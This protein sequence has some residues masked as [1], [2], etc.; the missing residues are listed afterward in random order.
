MSDPR[1]AG[2]DSQFACRKL[3]MRR[4]DIMKL[5]KEIIGLAYALFAVVALGAYDPKKDAAMSAVAQKY[6]ARDNE[7]V[8]ILES[9]LIAKTSGFM[10]KMKNAGLGDGEA[11]L[12]SR[13]EF[14]YDNVKDDFCMTD[15][16]MQH[17]VVMADVA[18]EQGVKGCE[19]YIRALDELLPARAR[20]ECLMKLRD[21][22]D[23]R[24]KRYL[25]SNASAEMPES[26]TNRTV[27]GFELG[28]GVSCGKDP[29]TGRFRRQCGNVSTFCREYFNVPTSSGFNIFDTADLCATTKGNRLFLVEMCRRYASTEKS[30][31]DA[32]TKAL[33]AAVE[34]MLGF[35]LTCQSDNIT[36]GGRMNEKERAARVGGV[37]HSGW[38]LGDD[39]TLS[40]NCSELI[41][42]KYTLSLSIRYEVLV[43]QGDGK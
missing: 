3:G 23:D 43:K 14:F 22:C 16:F 42:G 1:H 17:A 35:A 32:D 41:N 7:A 27:L 37:W 18:K 4:F 26:V 5:M 33:I 13:L 19:D 36:P 40:I 39:V 12:L 38:N 8:A 20:E 31:R 21:F 11:I 2:L 34:K 28:G 9:N 30:K 10:A 24:R 15:K 29:Q 25:V 6:L